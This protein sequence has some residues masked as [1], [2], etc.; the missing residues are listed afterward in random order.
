MQATVTS[1]S[2]GQEP[3]VEQSAAMRVM[4]SHEY[5]ESVALTLSGTKEAC[6][7]T[8]GW[9][10]AATSSGA[11][12]MS[13]EGA[14][15]LTIGRRPETVRVETEQPAD[16]TA[17]VSTD[18]VD[19]VGDAAPA[20]SA[21][22][23]VKL[24]A[25]DKTGQPLRGS[26]SSAMRYVHKGTLATAVTA[27]SA[28]VGGPVLV[29]DV[30]QNY[31]YDGGHIKGAL[32]MDWR[33]AGPRGLVQALAKQRLAT[34]TPVVIYCE[35]GGK[36]SPD[37]YKAALKHLKERGCPCFVLHGGY[38]RFVKDSPHLCE[39]EGGYCAEE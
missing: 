9:T 24:D 20:G 30:R 16:G 13:T 4:A 37:A 14:S 36:R 39:P 3:P 8:G 10:T 34:N 18:Q 25:V 32:H 28:G 33:K 19:Y 17:A 38:A 7:S 29:V 5:S 26:V 21:C 31:E 11:H 35:F 2:M 12:L 15:A 6:L 23:P 27:A 1:T 22:S